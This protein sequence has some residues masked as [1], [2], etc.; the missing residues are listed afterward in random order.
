MI[1][2]T[3]LSSW[4]LIGDY[5]K[6]K[7]FWEANP[8]FKAM[9]EFKNF[10]NKDRSENKSRTSEVMWAGALVFD[11][12]SPYKNSPLEIRKD[13]IESFFKHSW[14]YLYERNQ[15]VL[16][17]FEA[18]CVSEDSLGVRIIREKIK[19]K[20]VLLQTTPMS[21][22]NADMLSKIMQTMKQDY[23]L[24]DDIIAISETTNTGHVKGGAEESLEEKGLLD[25]D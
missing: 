14:E 2:Q 21:L 12:A 16:D 17:S 3:I 22:D 5:N 10:Y 9:P 15:E 24:L 11:A 18:L 7:S 25:I 23:K 19:E 6:F 13:N 4:D 1:H 8:V 20:L